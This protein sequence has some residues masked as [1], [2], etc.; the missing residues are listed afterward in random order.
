V[1][2]GDDLGGTG[3]LM[4]ALPGLSVGAG[5][6]I[7][8]PAEGGLAAGSPAGAAGFKLVSAPIALLF[9]S[10]EL[11]VMVLPDS[12]SMEPGFGLRS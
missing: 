4:I 8:E 5:A 3:D 12:T 1:S 7:V 6:I 10:S 9:S 11:V 2:G